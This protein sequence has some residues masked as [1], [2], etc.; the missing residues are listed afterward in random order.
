[1]FLQKLCCIYT[2]K[3][4][5]NTYIVFTKKSLYQKDLFSQT[6]TIFKFLYFFQRNLVYKYCT[7]SFQK[8]CTTHIVCLFVCL[9]ARL[10]LETVYSTHKYIRFTK[11]LQCLMLFSHKTVYGLHGFQRNS[12]CTMYYLHNFLGNKTGIPL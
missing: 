2:I 6:S 7:S 10:F 11:T 9:F 4:R 12:I 1:M 8:L 5:S 3:N